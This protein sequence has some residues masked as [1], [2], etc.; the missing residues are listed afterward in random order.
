MVPAREITRA[1]SNEE[2]SREVLLRVESAREIQRRRFAEW[3]HWSTN[4]PI[5]GSNSPNGSTNGPNGHPDAPN[6]NASTPGRPSIHCNAE[7]GIS[8]IEAFCRIDEAACAFL[9][10]AID[11]LLLSARATHRSLRV[12]RTIADLAGAQTVQLEHVA[13][14]VQYQALERGDEG[15]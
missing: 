6:R 2:T 9:Q 3:C 14:A 5:G 13:E 11:S 4:G 7:M 1:G 15:R 10:K 8:E 12:A